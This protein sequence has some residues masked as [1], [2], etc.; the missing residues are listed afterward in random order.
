MTQK[1]HFLKK[2]QMTSKMFLDVVGVITTLKLS[3]LST[4][5]GGGVI[6]EPPPYQV[7]L[8]DIFGLL[9]W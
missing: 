5:L 7:G 2:F 8:R 9:E 1:F 3:I 6:P 4:F